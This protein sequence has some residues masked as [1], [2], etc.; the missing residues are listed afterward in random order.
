MFRPTDPQTSLLES[1]HL[2]PPAKRARLETSWARPFRERVLPLIDE[3][4]FR[5]AFA[6]DGVGRPNRS[7]RLL[8]AVHLLKEWNDLTD[9][10][11]LEQLEY[12]LQ[13]HYALGLESA[14]AH[15]CQKTLHNY[16][17]KLMQSQRAQHMFNAVTK[18]L[19]KQDGLAIGR[20]R[21]DST[22]V[23]SN[24]AQLTRLGLFTET[25]THFL[26][27]L[28]RRAPDTL[29]ALEPGYAK[30]YLEREGYFGDVKKEQAR[31]R[32]PLVARDLYALVR[33]FEDDTEILSW[34]SYHLL[35]R[36]LKDQCEVVPPADAATEPVVVTPKAPRTIAS[37]S[38]QSPHDPDATYGHKGKGYQLQ[39][40]ETCEDKNPYQLITGVD[41]DGAHE[42]DQ[43]AV[44]PMVEQ[45]DDKGMKPDTLF[46]DTNYGSGKNL[47]ACAEQGVD[48][49]APVQNPTAPAPPD[50]WQEAVE[51][52]QS[53]GAPEHEATPAA[54]AE[55]PAESP[56]ACVKA[57]TEAEP[58]PAPATQDGAAA[59][60]SADPETE[61]PPAGPAP[62]AASSADGA[63][64]PPRHG[65]DA[66]EFDAT[67]QEV[68]S[69]PAGEAPREQ[70]A[71]AKGRKQATFSADACQKCP[72]AASCPTRQLRSGERRLRWHPPKA[73]TAHRQREQQGDDFK[74]AYKIRSGV[75]STIGELKNCH[76]GGDLRV[77]R[78]PQVQAAL[79]LK[80]LAL[81]VKRAVTHHA[82][83]MIQQL[84]SPSEGLAPAR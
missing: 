37:D 67:F 19:A 57:P 32:L 63:L 83:Q 3:E 52:S 10:Q 9:A 36:L 51:P 1:Y 73:A 18:G 12:N 65:L 21:L 25:I 64:A 72:L 17:V 27:D 28:R 7:I 41:L 78:R 76:G 48:L 14:A 24:I 81:N 39:V 4:V 43:K 34:E 56:P 71:V 16:R 42:S 49:M 15:L 29:A 50:R 45:L 46:G 60:S 82:E 77:R 58:V 62:A 61:P 5:E 75:E 26:R 8:T 68:H 40:S 47:I 55:S 23:I 22:Q 6:A 54:A 33:A 38:L 69:C 79:T 44:E 13:W 31:R 80:A 20:Q 66:F 70:E 59:V 84:R 74:E 11:V 30:R 35:V 2:L 53:Q